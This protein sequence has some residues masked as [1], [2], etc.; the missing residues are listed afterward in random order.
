MVFFVHPIG[1]DPIYVEDLISKIFLVLVKNQ[2][3]RLNFMY[4]GV[5][6]EYGKILL[7]FFSYALKSLT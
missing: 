4:L 7:A 5:L 1:I 3:T 2:P 6:G